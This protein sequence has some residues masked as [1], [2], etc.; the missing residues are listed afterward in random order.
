MNAVHL[1]LLFVQLLPPIV[2]VQ[3]GSHEYYKIV[4]EIVLLRHSEVLFRASFIALF[5]HR[6]HLAVRLTLAYLFLLLFFVYVLAERHGPELLGV[7]FEVIQGVSL[8]QT[9]VRGVDVVLPHAELDGGD[10]ADPAHQVLL[11]GRVVLEG[12]RADPVDRQV[13]LRDFEVLDL[14]EV[15]E[16]VSP[17]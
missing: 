7:D 13:P 8:M 2:L 4:E 3:L 14:Q 5:S 11:R 17:R 1:L 9:R 16:H 12:L 6:L 15:Q 10:Q